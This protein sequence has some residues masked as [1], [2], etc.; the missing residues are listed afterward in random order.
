MDEIEEFAR[1]DAVASHQSRQSRA[2]GQEMLLLHPSGLDR[3]AGQEALDVG[4]HSLVDQFEQPGGRRIEAIV[5]VED[6]VMDVAEVKGFPLLGLD[7]WEHAY[8]LKYQNKRADY[9]E[10]WWNVVNWDFVQ[11]RFEQAF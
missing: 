2:V 4:A 11:N 1:F 10:S 7:V 8:Y 9:I 3:I 6:P 5:E